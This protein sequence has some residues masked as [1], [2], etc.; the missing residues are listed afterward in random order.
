MFS[1]CNNC[2]AMFIDS[3]GYARVHVEAI[4][5]DGRP[6]SSGKEES[7][8]KEWEDEG[9]KYKSNGPGKGGRIVKSHLIRD[10]KEICAYILEIMQHPVYQDDIGGTLEGVYFEWIIHNGLYD[11]GVLI[12][13]EQMM[14]KA[15]DLD[16]GNTIYDD[17][18]GPYNIGSAIMWG[19]YQI[20]FP[21]Q[22]QQDLQTHLID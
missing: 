7:P 12:K 16:F 4:C 11:I 1:Y 6:G 17:K 20:A 15:A 10:S 5:Y 3:S 8:I 21:S 14:A 2:P 18:H 9:V 22:A 19:M 13:S